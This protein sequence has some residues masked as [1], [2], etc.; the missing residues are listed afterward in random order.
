MWFAVITLRKLNSAYIETG[1]SVWIGVVVQMAWPYMVI[2]SMTY[3]FGQMSGQ[4]QFHNRADLQT[5]R[6]HMTQPVQGILHR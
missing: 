2:G 3:M 5:A 4:I 1:S 6:Q